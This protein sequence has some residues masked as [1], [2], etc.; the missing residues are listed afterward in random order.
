MARRTREGH[1][2]RTEGLNVSL[3]ETVLWL[4]TGVK[5]KA[6]G[7]KPRK[8]KANAEANGTTK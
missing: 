6:E 3:G 7:R 5:T 2:T 8:R 1:E 4:T